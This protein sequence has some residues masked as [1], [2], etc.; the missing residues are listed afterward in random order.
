MYKDPDFYVHVLHAQITE[1]IQ[2]IILFC[3][4]R[5]KKM[6]KLTGPLFNFDLC[7]VNI[8]KLFKLMYM[9]K[10]SLT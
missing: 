10:M 2:I 3:H 4:Y 5:K 7:N 6:K 9:L 8:L 1:Q